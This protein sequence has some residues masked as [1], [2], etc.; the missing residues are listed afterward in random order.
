MSSYGDRIFR[1]FLV[2]VVVGGQQVDSEFLA[3][4][5]ELVRSRSLTAPLDQRCAVRIRV[6]VVETLARHLKPYPPGRRD[7]VNNRTGRSPSLRLVRTDLAEG[8]GRF[9]RSTVSGSRLCRPWLSGPGRGGVGELLCRHNH[10]LHHTHAAWLIAEGEHP[11]TIQ[12]R[13]GHSSILVR[14]DRRGT[15]WM[16]STNRTPS[17]STPSRRPHATTARTARPQRP[18]RDVVEPPACSYR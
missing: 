14:M 13:L 7:G 17:G 18:H 16:A 4:Q 3:E 2:L 15:S 5:G 12:T 9:S 1:R 10:D 8:G 6:A 11:K